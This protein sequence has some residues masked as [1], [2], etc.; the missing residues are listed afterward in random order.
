MNKWVKIEKNESGFS[1]KGATAQDLLTST[2]R[3]GTGQASK[4]QAYSSLILKELKMGWLP[5]NLKIK[6]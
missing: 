6:N 2:L 3:V 4:G 5:V 1:V